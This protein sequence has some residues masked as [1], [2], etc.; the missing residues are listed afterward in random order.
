MRM[1]RGGSPHPTPPEELV[2]DPEQRLF[3]ENIRILRSRYSFAY[4]LT[5]RRLEP[6]KP[7]ELQGPWTQTS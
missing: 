1:N 5:N 3:L 7:E 4:V 2:Y 6:G